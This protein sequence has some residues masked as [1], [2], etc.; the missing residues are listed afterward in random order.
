MVHVTPNEIKLII[1][2]LP[3]KKA[4][5]HDHITNLMFEKLPDIGLVFVYTIAYFKSLLI[6]EHFPLKWKL[7]T[8]ILIKK[9]G[10]DKSNTDS[11]RPISLL[12]TL[13]KIF[14]K[15]IHTRL[16]DFINSTD[17][18]PKF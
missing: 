16:Q 13:S 9:P 7:A 15:V 3:N 6:L 8:V 12:T 5:R 4:P 14:E 18:I 10:K 2:T 17:T 1:K 11:Y